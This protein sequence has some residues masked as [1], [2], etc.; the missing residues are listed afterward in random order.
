[1]QCRDSHQKGASKSP[2]H[3]ETVTNKTA[4]VSAAQAIRNSNVGSTAGVATSTSWNLQ[5]VKIHAKISFISKIL[6]VVVE[7]FPS[8]STQIDSEE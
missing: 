7:T 8:N 4:V 3:A 6:K 1:L 5:R 2:T